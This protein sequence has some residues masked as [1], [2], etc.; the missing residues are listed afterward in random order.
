MGRRKRSQEET[1]D[2]LLAEFERRVPIWS[3]L[4]RDFRSCSLPVFG[5]DFHLKEYTLLRPRHLRAHVLADWISERDVCPVWVRRFGFYPFACGILNAR[6]KEFTKVVLALQYRKS[7]ETVKTY[8]KRARRRRRER[9]AVL[10]SAP[11]LHS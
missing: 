7:L 11:S 10:L 5:R 6:P 9:E 1:E 2:L 3:K 4:Q 8:L